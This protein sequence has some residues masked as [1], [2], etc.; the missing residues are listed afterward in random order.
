MIVSRNVFK[1]N[2]KWCQQNEA[3][4][5]MD[6][7]AKSRTKKISK[8]W[9]QTHNLRCRNSLSVTVN[10]L[11][12]HKDIA[13]SFKDHFRVD[14]P[15]LPLVQI[16]HCSDID[17]GRMRE[18]ITLKNIKQALKNINRGNSP[19]HDGLNTLAIWCKAPAENFTCFCL[20]CVSVMGICHRLNSNSGFTNC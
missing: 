2:L 19:G 13:N 5:I 10:G 1:S 4:I 15:S 8:F 7:V 3:W 14:P 20:T 16:N 9:Q 12:N 18:E 17:K 11:S 6:I